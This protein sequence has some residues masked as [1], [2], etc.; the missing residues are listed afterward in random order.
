MVLEP[1]EL[2]RATYQRLARHEAPP[3]RALPAAPTLGEQLK[4]RRLAL[5]LSQIQA[6]EQLE[7]SQAY[8]SLLERGA[9]TH[10]SAALQRKTRLWLGEVQEAPA[11]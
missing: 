11:L 4:R 8:L 1:P 5:G 10:L 9:K 3:A 2:I 6:A 7:I